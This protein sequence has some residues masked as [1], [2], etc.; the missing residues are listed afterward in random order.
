MSTPE[1]VSSEPPRRYALVANPAAGGGRAARVLPAVQEALRELDPTLSVE[2]T[3]SI[4]HAEDLARAAVEAGRVVAA[5][6]GDGLIG[7]VAGAV[8]DADGVMAPLPGGRGNDFCRGLGMPLEA[9]PAA[10]SLASAVERRID[11]AEA[12]GIPYLG[13]ASLGFDS[14][15]QVIANK[16]RWVRGSQV[17]TYAALRALLAWRPATFTV[18]VYGPAEETSTR[19]IT[20]W[21]VAAANNRY[22]GG[23]MALAPDASIEDGLLDVVLT[24]RTSKLRFLGSLPKVFSGRH[25]EDPSVEVLRARSISVEADRPFQVY[26]DGDPIADLP[27]TIRV[28]PGALQVL[29]PPR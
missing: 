29:A 14:D 21:A 4:E 2:L 1:S 16:A 7:R 25:I 5:L 9:A 19:Q 8:A 17:Y 22:Y 20:G 28:R 12:G 15:V 11:L 24:S 27:A 23:G 13:I 26:A 6:G 10:R 3:R 18:E